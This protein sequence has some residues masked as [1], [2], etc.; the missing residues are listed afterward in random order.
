M[1]KLRVS[2]VS[3][4]I[5]NADKPTA[6]LAFLAGA[7]EA[8]SVEYQCHSI[9]SFLLD[10]LDPKRFNEIYANV[11]LLANDFL[12]SALTPQFSL[13]VNDIQKFAPDVVAV[14]LFSYMQMPVAEIFLQI[15][16]QKLPTVQVIAGGPGVGSTSQNGQTHGRNL[17]D[18]QLVDFY[19]L[20]EGD[21]AF[22]DFLQGKIDIIGINSKH[23][24]YESWVP[25]ISNL[26]LHYIVGSYKKINH[27]NFKNLE[28]KNKTVFSLSTSRGCVRN[29]SFCDVA[30]SWPSFRYRSGR[31]V[32]QEVLKHYQEVGA[33]H[34][35]ITDSLINGSLKSFREFNQEMINIKQTVPGL[36][37]FSY[38]G[39]FIV[40][41]KKSHN[42]NFFAL[43]KAAGC[44]SLSIGVETG[45]DRLRAEMNKNF[46][47]KDLDH[48]FE[49]CSKYGIKNAV[50]MF[51]GYPTETE[52][53]FEHSLDLL[54][55]Y[56]K[57]LLD[58]TII[59]I[60]HNGIFSMI[61]DTPVYDDRDSIGIVFNYHENMP[62]Q[63]NWFNT[64][65]PSLTMRRRIERDLLFRKLA[66]ELQYP[67]PYSNRYIEYMQH[68]DQHFVPMSD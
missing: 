53:D 30:K 28:N 31:S 46:T 19:C 39:M 16:R 3:V 51:V 18:N 64:S 33:V 37:E 17:L 56:Q 43:M 14:S 55:R 15:I 7:C 49:M 32:A 10:Q 61:T 21:Q 1:N 2:C 23:H 60:N 36:N 54:Y 6:S 58:D 63:L 5:V 25:Q 52:Q 29:C 41:D 35:A 27:K 67:V 9:N 4:D 68:L 42:E 44:D 50:L 65:N 26:D 22:V 47:N 48:H 62:A 24:K 59:G 40:R 20:G 34:F 12:V 8:A 45:S 66:A 38:N 13:L 57:Y 11:K